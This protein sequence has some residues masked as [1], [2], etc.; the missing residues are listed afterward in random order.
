MRWCRRRDAEDAMQRPTLQ[1]ALEIHVA[2][3][4]RKDTLTSVT[5]CRKQAMTD[6]TSS[7]K[8]AGCLQL[9]FGLGLVSVEGGAG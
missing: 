9:G 5:P 2:C 7:G 4:L 1:I 6:V 3:W 8:V